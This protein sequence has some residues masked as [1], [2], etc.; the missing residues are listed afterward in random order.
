MKRKNYFPEIQQ[1]KTKDF[2]GL[3]I[4]LNQLCEYPNQLNDIMRLKMTG[5]L[6]NYF[7]DGQ[8]RKQGTTRKL[9]SAKILNNLF[10]RNARALKKGPYITS[11]NP[12]HEEINL[13]THLIK[14]LGNEWDLW[15]YSFGDNIIKYSC[16]NIMEIGCIVNCAYKSDTMNQQHIMKLIRLNINECDGDDVYCWSLKWY[17]NDKNFLFYESNHDF[18]ALDGICRI[19]E[20]G[21]I[22]KRDLKWVKHWDIPE[23]KPKYELNYYTGT[24]MKHGLCKNWNTNGIMCVRYFYK[25]D[26][27][28][29]SRIID[30][31]SGSLIESSY[32]WDDCRVN[33][34]TFLKLKMGR[35]NASKLLKL[36]ESQDD[37]EFI[38]FLKSLPEK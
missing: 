29:E 13:L 25:G 10:F 3:R 38:E 32:N 23:K 28:G 7:I 6:E 21:G 14:Y 22:T 4:K 2:N 17:V 11:I 12:N 15:C 18:M 16:G 36:N 34:N 27:Y 35:L 20:S 31:C 8:G 1:K 33:Y 19:N 9:I 5:E 26:V 30:D 37:M 24:M